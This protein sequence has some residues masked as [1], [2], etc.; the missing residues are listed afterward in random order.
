MQ[1]IAD[2]INPANFVAGEGTEQVMVEPSPDYLRQGW[3]Y[4]N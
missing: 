4:G 2:E 1:N 3:N